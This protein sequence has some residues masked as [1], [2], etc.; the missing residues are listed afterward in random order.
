MDEESIQ[1]AVRIR[2]VNL[3][4]QQ[5]TAVSFVGSTVAV[6]SDLGTEQTDVDCILVEAS[7]KAEEASQERVFQALGKPIVQGALQGISQG[8]V[9]Y[10]AA[11]SGKTFTLLGTREEPGLLVRLGQALLQPDGLPDLQP[12]ETRVWHPA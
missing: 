2:P 7:D 4:S 1:I 10:G 9:F 5:A 3:P 12:V 11:G 6:T 8:V